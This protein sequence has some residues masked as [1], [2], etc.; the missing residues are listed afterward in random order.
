MWV[1][2]HQPNFL[3]WFGY[4]H[5]MASVDKFVILDTAQFSKGSFTNRVLIRTPTGKAYL[6]VP[7]RHERFGQLIQE[8]IPDPA[9]P[10]A[11]RIM[12]TLQQNYARSPFF[13]IYAPEIEEVLLS[14]PN[15]SLADLNLQLIGV[16]R[17]HLGITTPM[18]PAS[19]LHVEGLKG[20]LILNLVMAAGGTG[21]LSGTGARTYNRV[22][23][24]EAAGIRLLYQ[25]VKHPHYAAVNGEF[26]PGLSMLDALFQ[27]GP[28]FRTIFWDEVEAQKALLTSQHG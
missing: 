19:K 18:I 1:A 2:V 5:K 28:E 20:E 12:R 16:V 4:F 6:T 24:F 9:Q 14:S 7:V 22:S 23:D 15:A 21:Y 27:V 10:W 11:R 8:T 26:M 13:R 3:P 17:R 25:S